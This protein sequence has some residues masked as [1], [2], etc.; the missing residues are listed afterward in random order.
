MDTY[1]YR[2]EHKTWQFFFPK[3]HMTE[4]EMLNILLWTYGDL[5]P[6]SKLYLQQ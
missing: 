3:N 1:N 2:V 4:L 5:K 6:Y